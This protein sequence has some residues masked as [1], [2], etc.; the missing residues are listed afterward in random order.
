MGQKGFAKIIVV[1]VLCLIIASGTYL[2]LHHANANAPT[3]KA[4][5]AA[6]T[7]TVV[8]PVVNVD[9]GKQLQTKL[10]A[11]WQQTL[12]STPPD[13]NVDVALY[14]SATGAV[15]HYTVGSGP[16][17]TASAMKLSLLETLLWHN[18]QQGISSM[19]SDQ[20]AVA[21]PMIE[22]SDNDSASTMYQTDG[23]SSGLNAFFQKVG[24]TNTTAGQHWGL[25]PTT[26]PDQ[27]KI[28][29]QVAY[30]GGLLTAASAKQANDLMDKVEASQ[31][32]GVSAGV[33]TGVGV[34]LK[35]GWL[36]NEDIDGSAGWN[37]NSVGHVHGNGVD[38]TIA[39]L[40]NKDDDM[41]DGINTI[42]ALS[43]VA[44]NTLAA[45]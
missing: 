32:W 23:W 10:E 25:T 18:Q 37:V 9:E 12:A 21:T 20:L 45:K 44:W 11:A 13:G 39:V 15:A 36:S 24:A 7:Q 14:D 2:G 40:T 16:F 8:Q 3:A 38:Y 35:N 33:P 42:Q 34:E 19:T 28:I 31:D 41:Q 5:K 27:L 26:A 1:L 22:E 30:P 6:A 4:K 29:N 43:T 17:I